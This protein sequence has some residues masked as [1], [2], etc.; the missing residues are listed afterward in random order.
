MEK[1]FEEQHNRKRVTVTSA[2]PYIHG[3][4]H[5]GNIVG[6]LLPADIYHRYLDIEGTD[7]IFI[8]GSDVHRSQLEL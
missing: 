5:L 4:P 8:C 2:L 3:V 7:N 1:E 6:S